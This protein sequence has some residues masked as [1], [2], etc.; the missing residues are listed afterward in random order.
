MYIS[1]L[2]LTRIF[3]GKLF[4]T[5]A[6]KLRPTTLLTLPVRHGRHRDLQASEG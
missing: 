1:F 3:T 5:G 4:V 6:S 2:Y